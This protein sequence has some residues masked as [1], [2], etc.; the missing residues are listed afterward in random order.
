MLLY[1]VWRFIIEFYRDDYRGNVGALST[2]Q[3]ISLFIFAA[4]VVLFILSRRWPVEA[5]PQKETAPADGEEK[6]ADEEP[7][8]SMSQQDDAPAS[9]GDAEV[10]NKEEDPPAEQQ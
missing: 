2:S 9:E 3:F 4:G 5:L 6:P 10:G 7:S 8:E 1:A